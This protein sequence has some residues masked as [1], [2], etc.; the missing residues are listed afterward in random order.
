LL[1]RYKNPEDFLKHIFAGM[2]H[3]EPQNPD[4]NDSKKLHLVTKKDRNFMFRIY[5]TIRV[6]SDPDFYTNN[7]GANALR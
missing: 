2:W 4:S 1:K 6:L 5:Y 7:K 3:S